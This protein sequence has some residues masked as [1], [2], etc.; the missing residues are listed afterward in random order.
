MYPKTLLLESMLLKIH[1]IIPI[2][3]IDLRDLGILGIFDQV[4]NIGIC[5]T[6]PKKSHSEDIWLVVD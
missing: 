6:F 4:K 2:N 3:R 5:E 1:M